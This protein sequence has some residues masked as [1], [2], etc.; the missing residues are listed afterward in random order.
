MGHGYCAHC[1]Q[2]SL[3]GSPTLNSLFVPVSLK[4][5]EKALDLGLVL[6]GWGR[7]REGASSQEFDRQQNQAGWG[8]GLSKAAATV[9]QAGEGA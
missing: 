2:C 8:L 3:Q 7:D 6:V 5:L 4:S 1:S 9:S